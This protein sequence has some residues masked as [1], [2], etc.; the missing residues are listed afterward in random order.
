MTAPVVI[1]KVKN[2]RRCVGPDIR[3]QNGSRSR[4]K[5][6]LC[7]RSNM[8]K[9]LDESS[10]KND[11]GSKIAD[12]SDSVSE[13]IGKVRSGGDKALR[14]L[15]KKFDKFDLKD[16]EVGRDE[17]DDAYDEVDEELIDAIETAADN[18]QRFH[19]MQLDQDLWMREVEPG[20]IL[21]VKSTPLERI[22]VYVP[23]GRASYPSTA[24]MGIIP[25]RVAG[26]DEVICCT[27][28]PAAPA[29]LVAMDIAGADE[30]YRIGGVQAIAAMAFG[31]ESV[32]R[33]QKIVGPGNVY[34]TAA[35]E[36]LRGVVEIDFPAGPSE[37]GIIADS[38][39]EPRFIAADVLAQAEHDPASACVLVTTD[40]S[41]PE[42]VWKN[43][44]TMKKASP[45]LK[46]IDGALGNS[47]YIIAGS[48]DEAVEIINEIAPEHLS[49]VTAD[50]MDPLMKVRNAGSIF[51][52][53]YSP[54]A[55][56][57]YASGTN[58]ILPTA[59]NASVASGLNTAHF[60]KTS[61]IQMISRDG[62]DNIADVIE[63]I[64]QSEGL[65]AHRD[66]VRVRRG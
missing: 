29:T 43:I 42:K 10:W 17:I 12:V 53:P 31:T 7:N 39:A 6:D 63:K 40:A 19:E 51:L 28:P 57:D 62:L 48:L 50:V 18:I 27:P 16:I 60:R 14:E 35:K 44:E 45:R 37:I 24:L 22:G 5:S 61:T 15:T 65:T 52:G 38:T 33:V 30:I 25:A 2:T 26:V 41:L 54:V 8:W 55:A 34:V 56:G 36:M 11:R 49:I 23:G 47:G 4:F 9:Q 3:K 32:E 20:V 1:N 66:S 58:H 46:I 59:G 64:S 21:G 13:I